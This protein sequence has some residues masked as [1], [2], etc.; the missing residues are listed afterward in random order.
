MGGSMNCDWHW[1]GEMS[2]L[3]AKIWKCLNCGETHI[4]KNLSGSN[5]KPNKKYCEVQA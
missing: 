4:K 1:N 3:G 2:S 5:R